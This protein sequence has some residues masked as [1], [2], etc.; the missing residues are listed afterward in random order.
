M[1]GGWH[2]TR[3]KVS[4]HVGAFG[5]DWRLPR[6]APR[7]PDELS[8]MLLV[9]SPSL[10]D[11]SFAR[12]VVLVLDHSPTGTLGL[13]LNRP[14]EVPVSEI[15]LQWHHQ[16]TRALP[17]VIFSGGPVSPGAVIGLVRG[18]L[19]REPAGW[20]QVLGN[21]GTVDLSVAPDEQPRDLDGV[22]LFSGYSGWSADQ[23]DDE[24]DEG[25]WFCLACVEA[26]L[27]TN[28]P[29]LLWRDV[30]RRQGGDL[31]LLANYPPHPSVN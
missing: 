1:A 3:G 31:G 9:A 15:L 14:T 2:R 27:L 28:E 24:I 12:T 8:G 29:S 6:E 30:L 20:R 16:A 26:D 10:E 5:S 13:V 11:P 17:A 23:L 4:R 7:R 25:A 21:V 22:L 19:G 18:S